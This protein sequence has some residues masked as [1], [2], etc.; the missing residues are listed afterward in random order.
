MFVFIGGATPGKPERWR[1][2]KAE[3][4]PHCHNSTYWILEKRRQDLTLFFIPLFSLK[5]EYLYYCPICGYA[6]EIDKETFERK[7]RFEAEKIDD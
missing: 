3:Y 4:C 6:K 5:T 1:L 7:I 2:K